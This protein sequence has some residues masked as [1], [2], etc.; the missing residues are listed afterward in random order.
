MHIV[1]TDLL[2]C[3]RCGPSFGLILLAD[4]VSERRVLAGMLGCSN[5]RERWPITGGLARLGT[6]VAPWAEGARGDA[7]GRPPGHARPRVPLDGDA[8]AGG[9]DA[10]SGGTWAALMGVT[11]GPA[12]VLVAGGAVAVAGAVADLVERLEVLAV[13][14]G[15]ADLPERAGVSRL[16][17]GA[18]L[19]LATGK[20]AAATLTG[21]AADA[22]LEEASRALRPT[23]RLV[24]SP[25]PLDAD[26]RLAAAGCRVMARE[27]TTLIA[28]RE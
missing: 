8:H 26:A 16:E 7:P 27:A 4:R 13:G 9:A 17:A 11:Q 21:P 3:P 6:G 22:W 28:L 12:F 20:I 15:A 5:C 23:G 24:L 14:P 19:P 1:A 2:T 18:R 25:V 10:D